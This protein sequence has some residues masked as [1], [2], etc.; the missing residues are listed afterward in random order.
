MTDYGPGPCSTCG[1]DLEAHTSKQLSRCLAPGGI[2]HDALG[3][4]EDWNRDWAAGINTGL[5]ER[6]VPGEGGNPRVLI[7]GE[8]PGAQEDA[9]LRPFVG[10]AGRVLRQLMAGVGLYT[11]DTPHFGEPNCWLTNV[12]HFRPPGNRAP[13]PGEIKVARTGL[14]R[15]WLAVGQPRVVVPVGGTA[16]KALYG[17]HMSIM[18]ESGRCHKEWSRTTTLEL[19]VW[20]MIHPSAGLRNRSLI[21]HIEHDWDDFGTWL[22]ENSRLLP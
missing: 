15:E 10:P 21:K 11:G 17:K 2:D 7:V 13:T 9:K 8:A 4:L 6:Y 19:Y 5:S 22:S 12:V 16:L 20:P 3:E 14:R 18:H 1:D